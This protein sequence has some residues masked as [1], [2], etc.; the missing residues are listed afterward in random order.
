MISYDNA[1]LK[2]D[3]K[4]VNNAQYM[5]VLK[6]INVTKDVTAEE[7]HWYASFLAE[8][9]SQVLHDSI[10]PDM[11][12]NG[13]VPAEFANNTISHLMQILHSRVQQACIA[14]Q[15]QVNER[16]KLGLKPL[17]ADYEAGRVEGILNR[18]IAE[19][20]DDI[21]WV[22]D[23]PVENFSLNSISNFCEKN[24]E[25]ANRA[26]I[27]MSL[28]RRLNPSEATCEWCAMLA[29]TYEYPAPKDVYRRHV[30]CRCVVLT[31]YPHGTQDVW[32]K[33]TFSNNAPNNEVVEQILKNNKERDKMRRDQEAWRKARADE[34][35]NAK[36][37]KELIEI[38]K[39]RGYDNP[40]GWAYHQYFSR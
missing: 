15:T 38:A 9:L 22:L 24:L 4:L 3:K 7:V 6:K 2:W 29:G 10:T 34:V 16:K 14:L 28:E 1:R 5:K 37:M 40:R 27:P 35:A 33:S 12:V 13:K 23:A 36:T 26:G 39:K 25:A 11:L 32:S 18:L 19:Y 31:K 17:E 30:N 20:Y 8:T 21:D